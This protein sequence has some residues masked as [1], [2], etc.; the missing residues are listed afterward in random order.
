MFSI[1]HLNPEF[2]A[3]SWIF[4]S[5]KVLWQTF[6]VFNIPNMMKLC[7]SA[8]HTFTLWI[9]W[10]F[11]LLFRKMNQKC[12][13]IGMISRNQSQYCDPLSSLFST[14]VSPCCHAQCCKCKKCKHQ[15]QVTHLMDVL[16]IF[17]WDLFSCRSWQMAS[18][19]F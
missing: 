18:R 5:I 12:K 15:A 13:L 9:L 3:V 11:C 19:E 1:K 8:L 4:S 14:T 17:V 2:I 10:E 16:I 6:H 7:F